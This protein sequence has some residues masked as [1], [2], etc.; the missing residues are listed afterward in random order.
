MQNRHYIAVFFASFFEIGK[1]KLKIGIFG[2]KIG[3][4]TDNA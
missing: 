3:K 2:G 1:L 4:L